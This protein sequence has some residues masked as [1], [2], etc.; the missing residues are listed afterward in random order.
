MSLGSVIASASAMLFAAGAS[1]LILDHRERWG[2]GT[3]VIFRRVPLPV[4]RKPAVPT[5]APD[6]VEVVPTARLWASQSTVTEHGVDAY[7]RG[8][9]GPLPVVFAESDG[10]YTIV[11]GH[12]RI[13]A[14]L[15]R[16]AQ[17]IRA[18]VVTVPVGA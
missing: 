6:R 5:R 16:G 1:S 7:L 12:H 10:T 2:D 11:D 18:R 4:R 9:P 14:A 15:L 17:A 8:V 13:V 3:I